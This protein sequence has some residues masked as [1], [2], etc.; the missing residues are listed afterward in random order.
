MLYTDPSNPETFGN[1]TKSYMRVYGSTVTTANTNGNNLLRNAAI[2]SQLEQIIDQQGYGVKVRLADLHEIASGN[3]GRV[4][5]HKGYTYRNG[6]K[7]ITSVDETYTPT[8]DADRIKAILAINRMTGLD[9]L[10]RAAA[11]VA[12]QESKDL[13][14][15]IVRPKH[16]NA[17]IARQ[18]TVKRSNGRNRS[19]LPG[20]TESSHT[21]PLSSK[22]A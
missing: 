18:G 12:I 16:K 14:H 5:V 20:K 19:Q 10:H 15:R 13:Y 21:E 1:A 17:Q 22:H 4:T 2:Q 11:A 7:R 6:K 3:N 8:T 9:D